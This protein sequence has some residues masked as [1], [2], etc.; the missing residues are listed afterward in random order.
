MAVAVLSLSRYVQGTSNAVTFL[1]FAFSALIYW[2]IRI[3]LKYSHVLLRDDSVAF[4]EQWGHYL[5]VFAFFLPIFVSWAENEE[6]KAAW[7]PIDYW[8]EEAKE[9]ADQNCRV[10]YEWLT[11]SA[12]EV[13]VAENKLSMGI[14]TSRELMD[15]WSEFKIARDTHKSCVADL[16][17][18][19][20]RAATRLEKLQGS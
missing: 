9:A 7:S 11:S 20:L 17:A 3:L 8:R 12:E 6:L 5:V 14:A 16:N 10:E 1:G 19:R 4:L 2:I 13:Q 15:K 18:R